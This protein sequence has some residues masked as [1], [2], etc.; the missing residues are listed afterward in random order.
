MSEKKPGLR[1]SED[2]YKRLP[3]DSPF[4]VEHVFVGYHDRINGPMEI[5]FEKFRPQDPI[6][7]TR[8]FYFRTTQ[9]EFAFESGVFWDRNRRYD[10]LFRSGDTAE[11]LSVF[12]KYAQRAKI[13][14][15]I[16]TADG[17]PSETF[18]PP[19]PPKLSD[20][21]RYM[22][23]V[24]M[25]GIKKTREAIALSFENEEN[26]LVRKRMPRPEVTLTSSEEEP[27]AGEDVDM[28]PVPETASSSSASAS[29]TQQAEG[30]KE[31][32]APPSAPA[33]APPAPRSVALIPLG[34]EKAKAISKKMSWILRHGANQVGLSM[35]S[36]GFVLMRDLLALP[37]FKGVLEGAVRLVVDR[38]EKTRY[39]IREE[40]GKTWIRANQGHSAHMKV[41]EEGM[42][43]R[44]NEASQL[45]VCVH[46]TRSV[47]LEGIMKDGLL[48]MGR[49]H[50]HFAQGLP[51]AD[52]VISGMRQSADVVIHLDVQKAMKAGAVFFLSDN[53]VVL[54]DGVGGQGFSPEFFLKVER[55][56]VTRNV[57]PRTEETG[58]RGGGPSVGAQ[59]GGKGR[60]WGGSKGSADAAA[61][62]AAVV[63]PSASSSGLVPHPHAA[64]SICEG[65]FEFLVLDFEATCIEGQKIDPQEIIEFPVVPVSSDATRPPWRYEDTAGQIRNLHFHS[66]VRPEHFPELS[67]FCTNL[68]GIQQETVNAAPPFREVFASFCD[69]MAKRGSDVQKPFASA[70]SEPVEA[71]VPYVFVTCGDFDVRSCLKQQC[72]TAGVQCPPGVA[73][74]VNMKRVF[75]ELMVR[76]SN[77]MEHMLGVLGLELE[78]RH[79]S[80]IDDAKNLARVWIALMERFPVLRTRAG[81]LRYVTTVKMP[82]VSA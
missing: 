72:R 30:G 20:R 52:G 1:T 46:G 5:E 59:R 47:A 3:W 73:C 7:Y 26:A 17:E 45:P 32:C 65:P 60:R 76:E 56:E 81:V 53:G 18:V 12:E 79:H 24:Q 68:T 34:P 48:P 19:Q 64:A 43:T 61:G 70:I 58:E 55:R 51:G 75:S 77:G 23:S 21:D 78:G 14:R 6:P 74:Y 71:R 38:D 54:S 10:L 40:D 63:A 82:T 27:S 57:P 39:T 35:R 49:K 62:S 80:G 50:V 9:P 22:F 2:V 31:G 44:V 66:Y 42:L 13:S 4:P 41:E 25:E 29:N 33:A 8:I 36:D 28:T 37:N 11:I 15:P 16:L 69:W 67:E